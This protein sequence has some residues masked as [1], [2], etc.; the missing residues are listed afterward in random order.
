MKHP[1]NIAKLLFLKTN[2]AELKKKIEYKIF[3]NWGDNF[4][5]SN[6][7]TQLAIST[8][9]NEI[10]FIHLIWIKLIIAV[11]VYIKKL[12]IIA[13]IVYIKKLL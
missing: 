11:I 6:Y 13:V 7:L 1:T 12:L 4:Y 5:F 8:S 2:L 3:C 9:N 10:N